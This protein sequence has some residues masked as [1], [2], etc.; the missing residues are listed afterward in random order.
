MART[1]YTYQNNPNLPNEQYRHAFTQK[2]LDETME[3]IKFFE[4]SI[5]TI[6]LPEQLEQI[7]GQTNLEN[8][9]G[10]LC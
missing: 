8:T 3:K 1:P 2:E 9:D 6:Y 7:T 4:E 5:N 10:A